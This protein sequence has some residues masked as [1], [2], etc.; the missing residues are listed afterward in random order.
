[1]SGSG[2]Y[3]AVVFSGTSTINCVYISSDYGVNWN[4]RTIP[5]V[6]SDYN[7]RAVSMSSSGKYITIGSYSNG[8]LYTSS[9]IGITWTRNDY[10][11][12]SSI[13]SISLSATG[14]YQ[15]FTNTNGFIYISNNFGKDNWVQTSIQ[16][17]WVF[18][19]IG[20]SQTYRSTIRC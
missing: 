16:Q 2:K 14:Q 15:T 4:P 9:D 7:F 3:Q 13:N 1:M 5:I 10:I 8:N 6:S 12:V 20:F 17:N 11:N 18:G 19:Q